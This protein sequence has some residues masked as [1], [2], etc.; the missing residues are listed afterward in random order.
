M[1]LLHNCNTINVCGIHL[2]CTVLKARESFRDE[3]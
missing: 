1:H 2:I 3:H